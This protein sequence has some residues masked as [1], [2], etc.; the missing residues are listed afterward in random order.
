MRAI[1]EQI[2]LASFLIFLNISINIQFSNFY[3]FLAE[4]EYNPHVGRINDVLIGADDCKF[5]TIIPT[6]IHSV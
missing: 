4:E 1:T 5:D 2:I 6:R 3:K